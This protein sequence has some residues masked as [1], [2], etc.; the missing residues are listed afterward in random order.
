MHELGLNLDV[1]NELHFKLRD[2]LLV[3]VFT[4]VILSVSCSGDL[5]ETWHA[6]N[7]GSFHVAH[8][9]EETFEI[10]NFAT[11][12]HV[13]SVVAFTSDAD[14]L[15]DQSDSIELDSGHHLVG[16]LLKEELDSNAILRSG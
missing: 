3:E 12:H 13:I 8:H 1:A 10:I 11:G 7:I 6:M 2:L 16:L 9:A 15:F 5:D 14:V 4:I